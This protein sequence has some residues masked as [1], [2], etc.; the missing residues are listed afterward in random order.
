M[1]AFHGVQH[2]RGSKGTFKGRPLGASSRD[3]GCLH[4]PSPLTA[5]P[6]T[7]GNSSKGDSL[8][9]GAVS[10]EMKGGE[11][12][13]REREQRMNAGCV[14]GLAVSRQGQE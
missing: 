12:S 11:E 3:I 7:D 10:A 2:G 8:L 6:F 1:A 5:A 4:L 13:K 14:L 9:V